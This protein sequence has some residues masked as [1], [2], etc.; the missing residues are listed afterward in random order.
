MP[1]RTMH[2]HISVD[3]SSESGQYLVSC[4]RIRDVAVATLINRLLKTIGN[5]QLVQAILD[6]E[7]RLTVRNRGDHR[8]REMA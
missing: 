1:S 5:D 3:R 2:L 7:D 6:D 8:F 4:A